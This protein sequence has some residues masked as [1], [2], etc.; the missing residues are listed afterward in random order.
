M[1]EGFLG[2]KVYEGLS[3]L[4]GTPG[5]SAGAKLPSENA[6]AERFNVSRPV[7]RQALVQLRTEGRVY[8]RKGSGNYVSEKPEPQPVIP[9]GAFH[10]IPD[11]R[12]FL[13]FRCSLE[14]EIAA[15]AARRCQADEVA[16]VHHCLLQWEKAVAAGQSAIEEDIA[17]HTAI[18]N[19]SGNRFF[20]LTLA[21]INAQ[22]R[23]AI[24]LVRELSG[25]ALASRLDD[26]RREHRAIDAAITAGDADKAKTAMASH[27]Q[28]GIRRLFE[29]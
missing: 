26:V 23:F 22:S 10:N 24:R 14:G 6:L 8:S 13:E 7:V 12:N 20:A 9:F 1:S 15:Q 3:A 21:A 29:G 27:L 16:A 11:V 2:D 17:F 28:N 5:F 4:F 25:R 19:A 18:A